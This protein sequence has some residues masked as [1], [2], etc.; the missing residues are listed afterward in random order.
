MKERERQTFCLCVYSYSVLCYSSLKEEEFDD[1]R[2][3]EKR[4]FGWCCVFVC[5]CVGGRK[6]DDKKFWETKKTF[7]LSLFVGRALSFLF[8]L[9]CCCLLSLVLLSFSRSSLFLS[10]PSP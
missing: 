5:V 2:H 10:F 1:A 8:S 9:C 6:E 7:F 3:R 4:G